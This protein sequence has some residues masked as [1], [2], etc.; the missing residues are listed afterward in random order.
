MVVHYRSLREHIDALRKIGELCEVDKEVDW[1]LEV[2]AITRRICETGGPAV[3]FNRIKD[4]SGFR[5]L[6]A[7]MTASFANLYPAE[8]QQ[9]ILRDWKTGYGLP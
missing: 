9:R 1:N 2:G 8:L 3:L 4:A 5:M 6:A 7:P